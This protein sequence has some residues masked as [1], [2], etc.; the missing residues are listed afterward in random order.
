[1]NLGDANVVLRPRSTL[2]SL[3]L[4]LLFLVR[5]GG[6]PY[7][8]LCAL[9]LLPALALCLGCKLWLDLDWLDLWL[10][11]VP[12]GLWL[13]G[14][15]TLAAGDLMF[16]ES[17][18]PRALL[19]R[20]WARLGGYS[21]ALFGTRLLMAL[22]AC[23][24]LLWPWA[25]L[26][27]TFLPEALLLEGLTAGRAAGRAARL[28]VGPLGARFGLCL[29]QL[30][31]VALA[32]L[33]AQVLGHGIVRDTLQLQLPWGNLL[34]DGG[35]LYALAGWFAALPV[36]TTLRFL[37]YVDARTRADAWDVQVRLQRAAQALE[38]A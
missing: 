27:F 28:P 31:G 15:F 32:L 6:R 19:R 10:L 12:L 14:I 35:S 7:L 11:A 22:A 23:T 16:A 17:L 33:A 25:W 37:R 36:L 24:L 29:T 4:T 38:V 1:L 30:A 2:E 9:V 26:S 20:F 34:E 5:L 13:Q 21:W 3:D 18:Q 8:V